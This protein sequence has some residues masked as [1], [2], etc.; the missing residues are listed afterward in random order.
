MPVQQISVAPARET[1]SQGKGLGGSKDSAQAGRSGSRSGS[2]SKAS[3]S[4]LTAAPRSVISSSQDTSSSSHLAC[5]EEGAGP[6]QPNKHS[7]ARGSSAPPQKQVKRRHRRKKSI[8]SA[9]DGAESKRE[10]TDR[11]DRSERSLSSDRSE[12]GEKR[13]RSSRTRRELPPRLRRSGAPQ[14]DSSSEEEARRQARS[15]SKEKARRARRRSGSSRERDGLKRRHNSQVSVRGDGRNSRS[16]EKKK[17]SQSQNS[18]DSSSPAEGGEEHITKSY[19]EKG[20]GGGDLSAP[21]AQPSGVNGGAP[22]PFSDDSEMEV[23]RICHCEGDDDCP[24]IM[25]CRC[26]G[27]L[28]FVHQGCLNQWIKSSDTRCCELCK[29]DF[30][31]E[32]KLKPL[33]KWEKLH[34]SKGERRK[35]FSSVLFHLLA[36]VCTMLPVYVLV[37]R[38]AEEIRLGKNGVLEWPFWTKLIVVAIGCT[39][40]L[41]FMYVQCKV[42]L[43]LWRRLKAFNRI[44]TVQNCPE[45]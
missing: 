5:L 33:R 37:K 23:C 2:I 38:T 9:N 13:E 31:M 16:E 40:G 30:V 8:G 1:G 42:Y 28:S 7:H 17:S 32:T 25:P 3:S 12:H 15:W 20:P 4:A 21:T 19:Q 10:Q 36:I 6:R 11:T 18:E 27:S 14:T 26:T 29:F 22:A 43:Q 35:I 34:M 44:I 45:K 39:G 24:L 41:I